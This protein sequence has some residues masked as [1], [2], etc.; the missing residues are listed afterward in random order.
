MAFPR[1][2]IPSFLT[3]LFLAIW[4]ARYPGRGAAH[5]RTL[6]LLQPGLSSSI[7]SFNAVLPGDPPV[8]SLTH[9]GVV[10]ALY[11]DSPA[12]A[13]LFNLYPVHPAACGTSL[14]ECPMGTSKSIFPGWTCTF[15]KVCSSSHTPDFYQTQ[16]KNFKIYLQLFPLSPLVPQHSGSKWKLSILRLK[17]SPT[18]PRPS[19]LFSLL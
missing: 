18:S 1:L 6:G 8:F 2:T 11:E 16:V 13:S 17:I 3:S 12:Q 14:P 4:G 10:P 19:P 15:P 9:S 5:L 7:L